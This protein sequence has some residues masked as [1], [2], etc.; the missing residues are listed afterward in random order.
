MAKETVKKVGA[1]TYQGAMRAATPWIDEGLK[2]IRED[3][4]SLRDEFHHEIRG[5][6]AKIDNLKEEMLDRFERQ[7][8]TINEVSHRVTRVEGKL[9]GYMEALRTIIEPVK[10]AQKRRVG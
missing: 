10:V 8:A 1:G 4:R 9:E 5:L 3:I 6:D 2:A 7:L